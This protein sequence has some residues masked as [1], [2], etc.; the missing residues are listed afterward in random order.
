MVLIFLEGGRY[1]RNTRFDS[2]QQNVTLLSSASFLSFHWESS[3]C[4]CK[5]TEV[6]GA[7][8]SGVWYDFTE[9]QAAVMPESVWNCSCSRVCECRQKWH[10]FHH[11]IGYMSLFWD[12]TT[13]LCT[14][15]LFL[16]HLMIGHFSSSSGVVSSPLLITEASKLPAQDDD[17]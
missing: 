16:W 2:Y 7:H 10:C 17:K 6:M 13:V 3:F 14:E 5:D 1:Q 8:M 11:K 12:L 15:S 9:I 4:L